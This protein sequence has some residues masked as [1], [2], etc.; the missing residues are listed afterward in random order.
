MPAERFPVEESHVM[1]FA[2]A[3]GDQN[4]AYRDSDSPEVQS[5]GAMVAPLTF[6]MAASQFDPDNPLIPQAGEAW[7]GSG[8][9]PGFKREGGASTGMLHAEQKFHYHRP[10]RVGD[11]LSGTQRDGE[12][13]TKESRSGNTLTFREFCIDYHDENSDP[14]VTV[15]MVGVFTGEP[16]KNEDG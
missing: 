4:P 11:V 7:F 12:E 14:V 13:W 2:R 6:A 3:L 9:G 8:K 15:T 16:P 5:M 10:V 1:M